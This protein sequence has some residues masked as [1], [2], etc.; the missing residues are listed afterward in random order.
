ML[1]PNLSGITH[2][3]RLPGIQIQIT[4]NTPFQRKMVSWDVYSDRKQKVI[5]QGIVK[6]HW[7]GHQIGGWVAGKQENS[8]YRSQMWSGDVLSFWLAG[9]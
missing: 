1:E 8:W 5:H 3:F 7:W 2:E 6:I 9:S 4:S